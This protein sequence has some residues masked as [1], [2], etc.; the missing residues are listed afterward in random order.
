MTPHEKAAPLGKATTR[1]RTPLPC[2]HHIAPCRPRAAFPPPWT[3]EENNGACFIVRDN[4]GQAFGN[5]YFEDEPGRRS[6]AKL[7]T[8]DEAEALVG[9]HNR[10]EPPAT[11]IRL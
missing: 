6:A 7:L 9:L 2:C 1:S 8:R 10:G 5:F 4:T 3:I 11:A